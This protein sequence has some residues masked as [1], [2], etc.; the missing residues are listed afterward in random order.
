MF[1]CVRRGNGVSFIS[2][3]IQRNSLSSSA[4]FILILTYV[5]KNVMFLYRNIHKNTPTSRDGKT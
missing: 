2:K 4:V 5:V 3:G 1:R